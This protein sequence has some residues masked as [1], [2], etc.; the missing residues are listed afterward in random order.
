MA[1]KVF[2]EMAGVRD[3]GSEIQL[4]FWNKKGNNLYYT[5]ACPV[6]FSYGGVGG[7]LGMECP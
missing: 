2:E 3:S 5:M 4:I 1:S 7:R 6:S